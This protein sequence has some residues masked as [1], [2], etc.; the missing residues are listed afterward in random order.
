MW[1]QQKNRKNLRHAAG[2]GWCRAGRVSLFCAN[3]GRRGGDGRN[4]KTPKPTT[5]GGRTAGAMGGATGNGRRH[6]G[7][8]KTRKN[9]R[10]AAGG[11]WCRAAGEVFFS[12][13]RWVERRVVSGSRGSIFFARTVGG[14]VWPQQKKPQKPTTCGGRAAGGVRWP[15]GR[16]FAWG[17]RG[18]E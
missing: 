1:P 18:D 17:G 9:L 16:F 2:G 10:H 12:H 11:G 13:E 6:V 3:G 7:A 14:A 8:T 15:L 5:R 4:K